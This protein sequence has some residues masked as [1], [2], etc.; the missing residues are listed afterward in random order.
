MQRFR[1]FF[2]SAIAVIAA[3]FSYF[4]ALVGSG[5]SAPELSPND[6]AEQDVASGTY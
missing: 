5:I 4:G 2:F 3:G 1:W 6:I